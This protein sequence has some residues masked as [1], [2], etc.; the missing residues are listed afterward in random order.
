MAPK[1]GRLWA[2][3]CEGLGWTGSCGRVSEQPKTTFGSVF[4]VN[5]PEGAC[6][7]R[8]RLRLKG[9]VGNP[10]SIKVESL[11]ESTIQA[12]ID[13][14]ETFRRLLDAVHA[15]TP[16]GERP[17][18]LD[19]D[20]QFFGSDGAAI[21]APSK[22]EVTYFGAQ[23]KPKRKR[24]SEPQQMAEALKAFMPDV[25]AMASANTTALSEALKVS[26]EKL[27][28]VYERE[29]ERV[30]TAIEEMAD[31]A[32]SGGEQRQSGGSGLGL[33]VDLMK[34]GKQAKEFLN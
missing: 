18:V 31:R 2:A 13:G 26:I 17:W 12:E 3:H 11:E 1:R 6:Y 14:S 9:R 24:K 7:C 22:I 15:K 32:K 34:I 10:P 5:P 28:S 19:A 25:A 29:S 4:G 16:L 20:I 8:V 33:L 23:Q 27:H 21:D 30:D